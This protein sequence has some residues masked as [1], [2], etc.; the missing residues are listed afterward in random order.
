MY[1]DDET[2][3]LE[4]T[5][6]LIKP[7]EEDRYSRWD[8]KRAPVLVTVTLAGLLSS[9]TTSIF[10]P[11]VP[12]II[13]VF[14]T[15]QFM[16][17]LVISVF[18]LLLGSMPM[19]WGPLSDRYSRRNL[20]LFGI[21]VHCCT[22][23]L[24]GFAWN[25]ET[26]IAFRVLQA[27]GCSSLL[28]IGAGTVA[29]IYPPQIRGDALGM[30][31]MAPSVGPLIGPAIGGII[32]QFLGWQWVFFSLGIASFLIGVLAFIIVPETRYSGSENNFEEHICS[33]VL[34][35][36]KLLSNP[37]VLGLSLGNAICH[38][39]S[40]GT[41]FLFPILLDGF[42]LNELETGLCFIPFGFTAVVGSKV[43]GKISDIM[44]VHFGRGG[45]LVPSL[46]GLT[47]YI[48]ASLQFGL[49]DDLWVVLLSISL[50]GF[51]FSLQ[52]PGVYAYII[53]LF[54]NNSSGVSASL[55]FVQFTAGFIALTVGPLIWTTPLGKLLFFV[56]AAVLSFLLSIPVLI[57][58]IRNWNIRLEK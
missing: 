5:T 13:E 55:L 2:V 14:R 48:L 34:K 21:L 41:L 8:G 18:F 50:I 4:P 38:S 57:L 46:I 39:T 24:C 10:L 43:G 28:V 3:P 19:I 53:E 16:V 11:A 44:N 36:L 30:F 56:G 54:P 26:L 40:V 25:I 42:H 37:S 7:P 27:L 6:P 47:F 1:K 35:P 45:R 31:T 23:V 17:S 32:S 58:L 51:F 15:D 33:T 9:L 49:A 29:D 22:S 12:E 52:R 20:L